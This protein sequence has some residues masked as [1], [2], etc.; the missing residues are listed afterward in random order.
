M[1][2]TLKDVPGSAPHGGALELRLAGDEQAW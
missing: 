1:P 2:S